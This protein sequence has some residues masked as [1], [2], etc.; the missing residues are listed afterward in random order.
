MRTI[1][2]A[3]SISP[4]HSTPLHSTPLHYIYINQKAPAYFYTKMNLIL[5]HTFV[6]SFLLLTTTPPSDAATIPKMVHFN[7]RDGAL[8]QDQVKA[9][10]YTIISGKVYDVSGYANRHPGGAGRINAMKGT[11]GTQRLK[12]AHSLGFVRYLKLVGDFSAGGGGGDVGGGSN[13]GSSTNG[14][15]A[16]DCK[17]ER[18]QKTNNEDTTAENKKNDAGEGG[19][20]DE[21]ED[22]EGDD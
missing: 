6:V 8:T 18:G 3:A 5:L 10:G 1:I 16:A 2:R 21:G 11:D 9:K 19:E 22:L 13:G 7:L 14:G 12:G 15:G 4:L 20:G 17:T